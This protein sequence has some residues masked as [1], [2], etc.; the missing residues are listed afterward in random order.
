MMLFVLSDPRFMR[1]LFA[2][3]NCYA[4]HY[5]LLVEIDDSAEEKPHAQHK[6]VQRMTVHVTYFQDG[7]TSPWDHHNQGRIDEDADEAITPDDTTTTTSTIGL[8]ESL[9]TGTT[10]CPPHALGSVL[11]PPPSPIEPEPPPTCVGT[12]DSQTSNYP[13]RP[14]E[15]L[16]ES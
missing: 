11:D 14:K 13:V 4:L 10:S 2:K 7:S 6:P 9:P 16:S 1:V 15:A 8:A 5:A 12:P 3:F